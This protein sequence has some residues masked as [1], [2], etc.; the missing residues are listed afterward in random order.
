M[1]RGFISVI[2]LCTLVVL[3]ITKQAQAQ[4]PPL[5]DSNWQDWRS[6]PGMEYRRHMGEGNRLE[7]LRIW[8]MTEYLE[9]DEDQATRFFPALQQ[10]RQE[11]R[12]VDSTVIALSRRIIQ[13][14]NEEDV[15]QQQV[16]QWR[17]ELLNYQQ[18]K[19]RQEQNFL[20]SLPKYLT[21]K[22]QARYLIFERRFQ[23]TLIDLIEKRGR[24]QNSRD[25]N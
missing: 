1:N 25:N 13:R 2:S 6:P 18:E 20:E 11:I 17:Q 21:P 15:T 8:K 24:F 3:V 10:R 22:Q 7:M 5:P 14:I 4:P 12:A 9:L 16:N 19:L 23:Q